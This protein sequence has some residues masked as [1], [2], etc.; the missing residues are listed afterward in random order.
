MKA[1]H[2]A[3]RTGSAPSRR[4]LLGGSASLAAASLLAGQASAST[5]RSSPRPVIVQVFLRQAMDGLTTVVPHADGDLY[6]FRPTLAVPP[7]GATD[8]ALDLDGFFGFAPAAAPLLTPFNDGNL[9]V[10]HACG[11]PDSTRSHFEAFARME[12]ADPSLPLGVLTTG[13]LT[14]YLQETAASATGGLRGVGAGNFLP[15][16]LR[17]ASKTLPVP[18]FEDFQFPGRAVSA[19]ERQAAIFDAYARRHAPLSTTALDTIAS[20]GLGGIDF[21]AYV[22]ENGAVYPNTT[23]GTRLRNVAALIKGDIGLEVVNIDVE[24]WDLHANLGPLH[25]PMA[26]LLDE[27][28]RGLEAFYLDLLGHLDDYVLVCLSEFGRHVP[29]NAS[30]GLDHGHGNAMFVMGGH[31]N[32]GQVLADWPGLSRAVLDNGDLAITID[33]RDILGEV[34]IDR[35]GITNLAPIFPLHTYTSQGAIT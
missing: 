10:V 3:E 26:R 5:R 28:T 13:W 4:S 19:G 21:A 1:K 17:G 35:C 23:Y 18:N 27:L 30:A 20:F 12:I 14:R 2:N 34:L 8:G 6:A 16:S 31:V 15:Y 32:G 33:Y 29:E 9:I 11:S 22:P 25:G 7:P 24:G